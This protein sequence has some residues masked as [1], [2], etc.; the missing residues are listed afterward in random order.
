[1]GFERFPLAPL[2]IQ[3]EHW[4]GP[5]ALHSR[6]DPVYFTHLSGICQILIHYTGLTGG[7]GMG[8]STVS[9]MLSSIGVT[10]IDSDQVCSISFRVVS[11]TVP[12]Y[13]MSPIYG[14][15]THVFIKS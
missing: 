6:Y 2:G 5:T 14:G 8:K 12:H 13:I 15:Q 10:V 1:M 9:D 11:N 3:R 4:H 7:I